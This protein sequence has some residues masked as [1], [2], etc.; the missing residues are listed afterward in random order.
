VIKN[1]ISVD[2][3]NGTDIY[4][5]P[6]YIIVPVFNISNLEFA[7]KSIWSALIT[8]ISIA[9][10]IDSNNQYRWYIDRYRV[11]RFESVNNTLQKNMYEGF[12]FQNPKIEERSDDIINTVEVFRGDSTNENE[13]VKVGTF[14]D[15]GS[16][17][18]YGVLS[19]KLT[20]PDYVDDTTAQAVS[21]GI[22]NRQKD[23]KNYGELKNI[24]TSSRFEFGKYRYNLKP[25]F[26]WN[27]ISECEDISDWISSLT[28]GTSFSVDNAEY[29][30][31]RNS[32]LLETIIGSQN[33]YIE[34]EFDIK[35]NPEKIVIYI[36]SNVADN[37]FQ[38]RFYDSNDNFVFD[39]LSVDIVGIWN[40]YEF[41]DIDLSDIKKIR[42]IIYYNDV[43]EINIDRINLLY[44]SWLTFE[45][46]LKE[47][48]YELRGTE[49]EAE[50]II[51]D[52]KDDF[53]A[54]IEK[55]DE[56]NS[57]ALDIFERV[58]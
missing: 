32:F 56:K 55:I 6:D 20:I 49:L 5:N 57:I 39:T 33:D 22:I 1:I 27:I 58:T 2:G 54:E 52:E 28:G 38:I 24:L 46:S 4:Y 3:V 51:G 40:G 8:L 16:I 19:R 11:F 7:N 45:G 25:N 15:S 43:A 30:T 29:Y 18:K 9:N 34:Y 37:I 42:F 35:D 10:S 53:L 36:K 12:Y 48:K 47:V 13:L 41:T 23:I 44:N 50:L 31:G 17:G 14:S 21:E 26:Y